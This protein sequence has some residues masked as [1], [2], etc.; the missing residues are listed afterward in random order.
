[1]FTTPFARPQNRWTVTFGARLA[2]C[3]PGAKVDTLARDLVEWLASAR[4]G[5]ALEL[6]I[7]ATDDRLDVALVADV[8]RPGP[9]E[10]LRRADVRAA[11]LAQLLEGAGIGRFAPLD[12]PRARVATGAPASAEPG[13]RALSAPLDPLPGEVLRVARPSGASLPLAAASLEEGGLGRLLP[14]LLAAKATVVVSLRRAADSRAIEQR[15]DRASAGLARAR[16]H[17]QGIVVDGNAGRTHHYPEDLAA[18]VATVDTLGRELAWLSSLDQGAV[19]L[20]VMLVG[21]RAAAAPLLHQVQRALLPAL[22]VEWVELPV[23][24][25]RLAGPGPAL[26]APLPTRGGDDVLAAG[27]TALDERWFTLGVAAS[28]LRLPVAPADGLPGI[29]AD[30]L[31]DRAIPQTLTLVASDAPRVGTAVAARREIPARLADADLA[32]HLYVS[33]K[34]GVGKSTLVRTLLVDVARAGGGVGLIDPHG[35]LAD[36]LVAK[37]S[38]YRP[39]VLFDPADP[40]CLA[41]D[42]V[43]HDGTQEGIERA[44]EDLTSVLFRLFPGEMMGPMFDRHARAL[45]LPLLVAGKGLGDVTRVA[46]DAAFRKR[47]LPQLDRG[48]PLHEEVRI[49]W[50]EE[51]EGWGSQMRGEMA[52]YTVSKF[53]TLLKSSALR[54]ACDSTR[55]QLDVRR[56]LDEGGVLVARLPEARLGPVS[57]WFMGMILL[58]R[59]QSAVFSRPAGRRR[60]F[61]LAIDEFQKFVGGAGFGYVENER[62]LAPLL[63]ESRK[64]GLRLVLAHQYAAQL[65]ERTRDA[66]FGNVGSLVC[67]R[68]GARDA[69]LLARELGGDATPEELRTLPLYHAVTRLLVDGQP[70]PVMNVRTLP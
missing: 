26:D 67:F 55:R 58:S 64:F 17:A 42:P 60:P 20:A 14:L 18:A 46:N 66:I 47:I 69:E 27:H 59:L 50:E 30:L 35:D 5:L 24:A 3:R 63:S 32:R 21:P 2:S 68:A 28:L 61:T 16:A 56:V 45:L 15:F 48:N 31:A 29:P 12:Q 40:D 38:P 9:D 23:D 22:G 39:V 41:L 19:E 6:R 53:D 10:A 8:T 62:T 7:G 34:T 65:D 44:I 52:T 37:I 25:E 54:R 36:E 70:T 51:Y 4:D 43:A 11:E 33:G 13:V 1:V 57:A 49:F